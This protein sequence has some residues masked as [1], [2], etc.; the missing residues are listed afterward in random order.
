MIHK[1][2]IRKIL[3]KDFGNELSLAEEEEIK[4]FLVHEEIK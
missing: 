3:S 1:N 4:D 2:V